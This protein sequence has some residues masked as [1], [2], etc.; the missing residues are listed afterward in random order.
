M[1]IVE[2]GLLIISFIWDFV[3]MLLVSFLSF[4][5]GTWQK[6]LNVG[7]ACLDSQF[8]RDQSSST[9]SM[10]VVAQSLAVRVCYVFVHASVDQELESDW[11]WPRF[12]IILVYK[13]DLLMVL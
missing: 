11:M 2:N 12:Y 1:P 10:T 4:W 6:K 7:E 9:E 8:E 13:T 3:P 5:Q